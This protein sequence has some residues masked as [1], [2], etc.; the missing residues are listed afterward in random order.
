MQR[1][2]LGFTTALYWQISTWHNNQIHRDIGTYREL[3]S[4]QKDEV[5]ESIPS[6]EDE[7]QLKFQLHP[8]HKMIRVK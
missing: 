2:K 6:L 5:T 7:W 8:I 3:I 1:Y 4:A